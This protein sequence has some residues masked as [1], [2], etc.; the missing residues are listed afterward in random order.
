[1]RMIV[2]K[3]TQMWDEGVE[4]PL[5]RLSPVSCQYQRAAV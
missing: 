1:M 5:M 4:A 3:E 2:K